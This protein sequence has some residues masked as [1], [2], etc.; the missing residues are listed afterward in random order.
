MEKAVFESS[1]SASSVSKVFDVLRFQLVEFAQLMLANRWLES[2]APLLAFFFTRD[3]HSCEPV[4]GKF[5]S[6]HRTNPP[7]RKT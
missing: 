7:E 5:C 1:V 6:D 2:L 4:S 3:L